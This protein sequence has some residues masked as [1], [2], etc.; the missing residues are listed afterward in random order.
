VHDVLEL[1]MAGHGYSANGRALI[2]RRRRK[3]SNADLDPLN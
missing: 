3:P 1:R 2:A